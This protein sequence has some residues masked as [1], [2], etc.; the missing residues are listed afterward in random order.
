MTAALT[1]ITSPNSQSVVKPFVM[2]KA[3]DSFVMIVYL[4]RRHQ[5][6][7]ICFRQASKQHDDTNDTH[8]GMRFWIYSRSTCHYSSAPHS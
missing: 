8:F 6:D 1:R 3:A 5:Q 4:L 2:S 7:N